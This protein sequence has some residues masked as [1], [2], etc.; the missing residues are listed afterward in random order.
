MGTEMMEGW[1]VA[2]YTLGTIMGFVLLRRFY[3]ERCVTKV[4]TAL[5]NDRVILLI[6]EDGELIARPYYDEEAMYEMFLDR[7]KEDLEEMVK[8]EDK[9]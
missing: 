3:I 1:L 5:A 9:H 4:L 2:A 6:E 7:L 8:E